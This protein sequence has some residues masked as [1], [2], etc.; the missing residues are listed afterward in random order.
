M[1][2]TMIICL[3]ILLAIN[4]CNNKTEN[5][6][7]NK[8]LP[9]EN[10][11]QSGKESPVINT[12]KPQDLEKLKSEKMKGEI[13]RY[14]SNLS[15]GN[16]QEA[17]Q[18]FAAKVDQWITIKN[19]TPQAIMTEARRFL[20]TKNGVRY[21]PNLTNPVFKENKA[22]VVV[23]Q[24]WAGYDTILEVWL[25][26][27][28]NFKIKSYKEGKIIRKLSGKAIELEALLQKTP[29]V[30][31]PYEISD[32]N[33]SLPEVE[34]SLDSLEMTILGV[35]DFTPTPGLVND[36][37]SIGYFEVNERVT[38]VLYCYN[39]AVLYY[40]RLALLD[41]YSGKL[42]SSDELSAWGTP[43]GGTLYV[44]EYT[45]GTISID[46]KGYIVSEW[47]RSETIRATNK[48]TTSTGEYRCQILPNGKIKKLTK[49]RLDY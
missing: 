31:L 11:G 12:E 17:S 49:G 26:F 6:Q 42:I 20:S 18:S 19:T 43:L 13:K 14:F 33:L 44:A 22:K 21:T 25:E 7:R 9:S 8:P 15:K 16:Y 24:Q 39:Y 36:F 45:S 48:T 1:K 47:S 27:D 29:K 4:A 5:T 10:N 35:D 28:K 38:A 46:T 40:L 41:R 2:K 32:V 30:S 37:Y 34:E 3:G 23:R